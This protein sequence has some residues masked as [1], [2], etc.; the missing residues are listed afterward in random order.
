MTMMKSCRFIPFPDAFR[1]SEVLEG[2][3][4]AQQTLDL[5][6]RP[7]DKLGTHFLQFEITQKQ[8]ILGMTKRTIHLDFYR[9]RLS[10]R[11]GFEGITFEIR[12]IHV[13]AYEV[14][15]NEHTLVRVTFSNTGPQE[16]WMES[17]ED[18]QKFFDSMAEFVEVCGRRK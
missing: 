7:T 6:E 15:Q 14:D 5:Y 2:T 10:I 9:K 17:Q 8:L 11:G 13:K 16:F 18:V 3:K 1:A 12:G 4:I